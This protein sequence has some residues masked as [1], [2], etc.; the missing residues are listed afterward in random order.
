[1]GQEHFGTPRIGDAYCWQPQTNIAGKEWLQIDAG[2]EKVIAGIVTQGRGNYARWVQT[3][4]VQVSLKGKEWIWVECGRIFNANRDNTNKEEILFDYPVK[5]RYVRIYPETCFYECNLRAALSLCESACLD[6]KLDYRLTSSLAS[7]TEGPSLK[8]PWGLGTISSSKG[9]RVEKGQGL[10]VDESQCIKLTTTWSV[11]IDAQ[12]DAVDSTRGL[13][14][15]PE[16]NG[17][18]LY[19]K[20]G[21][22]QQ[23]IRIPN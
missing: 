5:A 16:W 23:H 8:T 3:L 9:Y 21:K 15:S 14:T 11:L 4:K 10:E 7:V 20:D 19:V 1:M 13:M 12:L 22:F 17:G 18:G 6:G 2:S